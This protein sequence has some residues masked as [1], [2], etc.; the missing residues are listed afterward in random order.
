MLLDKIAKV[1]K[2]Q[3]SYQLASRQSWVWPQVLRGP[4]YHLAI[5]C[6]ILGFMLEAEESLNS[7][8]EMVE[9]WKFAEARL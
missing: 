1:C 4:L 9:V 2:K 7:T 8:P 3:G 5:V 6:S